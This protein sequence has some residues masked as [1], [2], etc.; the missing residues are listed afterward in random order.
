MLY[1][2]SAHTEPRVAFVRSL[3]SALSNPLYPNGIFV[4]FLISNE[5]KKDFLVDKILEIPTRFSSVCSF[6]RNTW[7]VSRVWSEDGWET[8][9]KSP[10]KP[11]KIKFSSIQRSRHPEKSE[12]SQKSV[13]SCLQINPWEKKF[14]RPLEWA[15]LDERCL[16]EKPRNPGI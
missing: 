14:Q 5:K 10:E 2:R 9:W 16:A 1:V 4:F 12:I 11:G 3:H 13:S 6:Q 15:D 8:G 7:E